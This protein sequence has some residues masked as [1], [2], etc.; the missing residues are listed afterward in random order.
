MKIIK[1]LVEQITEELEDAEKY[2]ECAMKRKEDHPELAEL[3][4]SLAEEELTHAHRLHSQV[5]HIIQTSTEKPPEVMHVI[6]D[7]EHEKI[8]KWERE[9]RLLMGM[10]KQ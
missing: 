9:I 4:H 3:Y 7:W 1:H 8:V 10:F 6:W 5:V 2:A